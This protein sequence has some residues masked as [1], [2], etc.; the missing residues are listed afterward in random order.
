MNINYSNSMRFW[1][2]PLMPTL[3]FPLRMK[4]KFIFE[5]KIVRRRNR[6]SHIICW[7]ENSGSTLP[8]RLR[9]IVQAAK[10]MFVGS[11][12]P[13]S[14]REWAERNAMHRIRMVIENGKIQ[15]GRNAKWIFFTF[16]A[17]TYAHTLTHTPATATYAIRLYYQLRMLVYARIDQNQLIGI[18]IWCS[19]LVR[20]AGSEHVHVQ[21]MRYRRSHNILV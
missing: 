21:R 13:K 3:L 11:Y 4:N 9:A 1:C 10:K 18:H 12:R 20:R 7:C 2:V 15:S 16:L 6:I 14:T 8:A 19:F 17:F 5:N